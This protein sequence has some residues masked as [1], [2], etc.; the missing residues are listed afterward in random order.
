[1]KFFKCKNIIIKTLELVEYQSA[2]STDIYHQ[3]KHLFVFLSNK[4]KMI[5]TVECLSF[6]P[7][8]YMLKKNKQ[9]L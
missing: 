7:M 9:I 1:M 5:K 3:Y 4:L 8:L 6:K 2:L